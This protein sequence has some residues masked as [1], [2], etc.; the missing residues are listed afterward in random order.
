MSVLPAGVPPGHC[1]QDP[2][3]CPSV[4]QARLSSPPTE[5][6]PQFPSGAQLCG[7]FPQPSPAH[8]AA[9]RKLTELALRPSSTPP[10]KMP[11]ESSPGPGSRP[12]GVTLRSPFLLCLAAPLE[13]L[14]QALNVEWESRPS[15]ADSSQLL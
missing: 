11:R 1:P 2:R 9:L 14:F 15:P 10:A 4:D 6:R 5:V 7:S 13:G 3:P 8:G 12:P